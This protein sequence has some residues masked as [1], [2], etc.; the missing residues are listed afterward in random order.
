MNISALPS[1]YLPTFKNQTL[2]HSIIRDVA[3]TSLKE[4][5]VS[6]ALVGAVIPFA[7][8]SLF[9]AI[10]SV[11]AAALFVV[12]TSVRAYSG[13]LTYQLE[14]YGEEYTGTKTIKWMMD[15]FCPL[16]FSLLD[17]M[18]RNTLVHEAG[19]ACAVLALFVESIPKITLDLSGGS[20]SY[21]I[22]ALSGLGEFFGMETSRLIISAAGTAFAVSA[23]ALQIGLSYCMRGSKMSS[24]LI[25]SAIVSIAQ[26]VFYVLSALWQENPKAGH[27][28][29]RLWTVSH[30]HP[31]VSATAIVALPLV[32]FGVCEVSRLA[33]RRFA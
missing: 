30:I 25:A 28:F 19:H 16:S 24:Y 2:A 23:A 32:V 18:T 14:T 15:L 20:T 8:S 26:H 4:L 21:P 22:T 17:L 9:V 33:F 29:V 5:L 7:A 1:Q 11:T 12:N 27:D 6:L 3:F 31:I 10:V 13:Y